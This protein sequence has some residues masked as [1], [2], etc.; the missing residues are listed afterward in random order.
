MKDIS[1]TGSGYERIA[2]DAYFT[3]EEWCTEALFES[4]PIDQCQGEIWEPAC[5]TGLMAEVIKRYNPD[6]TSSDIY[7]WG[8]G[9]VVDFMVTKP[10]GDHIVTNPPYERAISEPFVRK[11]ISMIGDGSIKSVSMLMR[12][13]WDCAVGRHDLFHD[14]PYY[15]NK[16][17]LTKRPRWFERQKDDSSPRHNYCWYNWQHNAEFAK[18]SYYHPKM[19]T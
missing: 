19:K 15:A 10:R 5:G 13:E 4:L 17:V 7:D 9:D 1:M 3:I 16:I 11:A 8:Y 18:I 6:V 14:N 2:N 12:N